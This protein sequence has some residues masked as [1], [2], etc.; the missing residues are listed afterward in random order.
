MASN[1]SGRIN[2]GFRCKCTTQSNDILIIL[3]RYSSLA[4]GSEYEE[5]G[6]AKA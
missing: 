2:E 4:D 6:I 3:E 5:M 1:T